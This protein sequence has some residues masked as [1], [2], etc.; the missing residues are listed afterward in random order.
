MPD[1]AKFFHL[2]YGVA[3][4]IYALYALSLYLRG[5]RLRPPAR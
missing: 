1:N 4:T 3:L 2:A 5:R